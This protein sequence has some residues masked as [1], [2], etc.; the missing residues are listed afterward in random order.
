MVFAVI[1]LERHAR[2]D[3]LNP[4]TPNMD[5]LVAGG[6]KSEPIKKLQRALKREEDLDQLQVQEPQKRCKERGDGRRSK[7]TPFS[8]KLAELRK[9]TRKEG[10]TQPPWAR[11]IES[12]KASLKK[13]R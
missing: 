12:K 10:T 7:P 13:K 3:I 9:G 4:V 1:S 8:S 5:V 11:L 2:A 6:R